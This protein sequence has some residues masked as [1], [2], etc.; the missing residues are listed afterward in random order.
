MKLHFKHQRILLVFEILSLNNNES[1]FEKCS[2][3]SNKTLVFE[4]RL[5][6]ARSHNFRNI[7]RRKSR[8][9]QKVVGSVLYFLLFSAIFYDQYCESYGRAEI[10]CPRR[11]LWPRRN[12]MAAHFSSLIESASFGFRKCRFWLSKVPLSA[13]KKSIAQKKNR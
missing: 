2:Q 1:V 5:Q 8:K 9:K 11:I 13:F 12:F 7:D 10:L 4:N 3:T 6:I